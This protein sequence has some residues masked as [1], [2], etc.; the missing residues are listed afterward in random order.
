M[1]DVLPATAIQT[2]IG[3]A[4][5]DVFGRSFSLLRRNF[6]PFMVLS[7]IAMLPYLIFFWTS[8]AAAIAPPKFHASS[9]LPFLIGGIL[10]VLLNAVI[11]HSAFQ[12]MRNRPVRI[13][14]AVRIAFRRF[15]PIIGL[16]FCVG[17]GEILGAMLL[18]VPGLIL[19]TMWY[20]AVPVCV[21]EKLGVFESMK[22]SAALTKGR[23]WK[24]LGLVLLV[25]LGSAIFAGVIS[26]IAKL[27][28]SRVAL[29]ILQ[30][31][32]QSLI[33]VF[34]ALV[35]VVVYR[36]LRAARDGIDTDQIAAVF[37]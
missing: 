34:S 19:A 10:K 37:D 30:Y 31:L 33:A 29:V 12:D 3:F 35:I 32:A 23:R 18:I 9:G 28:L 4:M 27:L 16:I 1:S 6:V 22:R 11:V 26:A 7:G 14:E 36:D 2:D 24:V 15:W 21:V 5:G 13:G 17:I 8:S 25:G 20:L